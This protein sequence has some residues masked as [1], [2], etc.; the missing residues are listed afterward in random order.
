MG[1]CHSQ[2]WSISKSAVKN[3]S[4]L[5]RLWNF[6]KIQGNLFCRLKMVPLF[7]YILSD[8]SNWGDLSQTFTP[9]RSVYTHLCIGYWAEWIATTKINTWGFLRRITMQIIIPSQ[10]NL[11]LFLQIFNESDSE[12]FSSASYPLW[13]EY[14]I[15]T[16]IYKLVEIILQSLESEE[17]WMINIQYI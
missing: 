3:M 2:F 15:S 12:L 9:S 6:G 14:T 1:R 11:K 7:D 16:G 10:G 13:I 5:L 8:S 17:L 4:R